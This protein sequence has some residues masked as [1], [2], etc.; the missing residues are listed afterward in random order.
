MRILIFIALKLAEIAVLCGACWVV[1]KMGRVF[2]AIY[3]HGNQRRL[4]PPP[5][6]MFR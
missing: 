1:T 6:I 4:Q 5:D 3:S 2:S